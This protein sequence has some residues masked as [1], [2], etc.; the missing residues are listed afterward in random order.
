VNWPAPRNLPWLLLISAA[1]FVADRLS[2]AW[3]VAHIPLTGAIPVIDHILRISHWTN[4]GAAFS[5][6]AGA[7]SPREVNHVLTAVNFLVASG[8]LVA[9]ARLGSR[10]SLVTVAL[11][12]ILGGAMGNVHDRL[13]Y[14]AVIDFIEVHIF[15]YHWPDFNVADF[16]IVTGAC[17]IFLDSLLPRG[18]KR[19]SKG[20]RERAD[21][22]V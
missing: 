13:A 17:L 6:F 11:A 19:G 22:H 3:V 1:V 9:L 12:F 5:M 10:I 2:K 16:S 7:A 4:E 21:R 20:A 15:T 18:R 8:V 14:G